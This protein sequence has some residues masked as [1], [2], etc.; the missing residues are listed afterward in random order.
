MK[1]LTT[2]LLASLMCIGGALAGVN[3]TLIAAQSLLTTASTVQQYQN[4]KKK[5]QAAKSDP[6]YVASEHD[7]SINAGISKCNSAI[8]AASKNN[9]STT[10]PRSTNTRPSSGSKRNNT[11]A[12]SAN[13]EITGL[14]IANLDD[15][16]DFIGEVNGPLYVD[17]INKLYIA[18]TVTPLKKTVTKTLRVKLIKPDGNVF[19]EMG[20]TAPAGYSSEEKVTINSG[21]SNF[22]PDRIYGRGRGNEFQAGTYTYEAYMDGRKV[23]TT[24][25]DIERGS[26]GSGSG[27]G[28]TTDTTTRPSTSGA[29]ATILESRIGETEQDGQR[30]F[31][32][33]LDFSVENSKGKTIK[34]FAIVKD[35]D[36]YYRYNDKIV[37]T[38]DE[39]VPEYESTKF[40]NVNLYIPLNQLGKY[41]NSVINVEVSID[42]ADGNTM[43]KK[44]IAY[45]FNGQ[46]AGF[47]DF[48]NFTDNVEH[49]GE[50]CLKADIGYTVQ[51]CKGRKVNCYIFALDDSGSFAKL[52]GSPIADLEMTSVDYDINTVTSTE[53][54]IPHSKLRGAGLMGRKVQFRVII[55]DDET[56]EDIITDVYGCN[57][58]G[59]S[60]GTS[61]GSMCDSRG[62][63][64]SGTTPSAEIKRVNLKQNTTA[65]GKDSAIVTIDFDV[66]NCHGKRVGLFVWIYDEDGNCPKRATDSESAML[67]GRVAEPQSNSVAYNDAEIY[68]PTADL[69]PY[70][71]RTMT[72]CVEV[73]NRDTGETIKK[74][75]YTFTVE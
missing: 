41:R 58:G 39:S 3:R 28:M 34:A 48:V 2:L 8:A 47:I 71:G 13:V 40:T 36:S 55:D 6:G 17:D 25:F 70:R 5:F 68:I 53:L 69:R 31:A 52:D 75:N 73:D 1:R 37:G 42:D 14:I 45:A 30:C 12:S 26:A 60:T 72:L 19:R 62:T 54:Y 64:A 15:N 16:N 44:N 43:A 35:G 4:A 18:C 7:R 10:K 38:V 49:N 66:E 56:R 29:S 46:R 74:E 32:V 50:T 61:A 24:T 11:S 20:K 33:S 59:S 22:L 21:E 9:S 27:A 23:Y 51:N 65:Q 63:S 57:V 67:Y